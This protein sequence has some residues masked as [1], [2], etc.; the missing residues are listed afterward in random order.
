MAVTKTLRMTLLRVCV[1]LCV[2]FALPAFAST[3]PQKTWAFVVGLVDFQDKSTWYTFPVRNRREPEVV[4]ALRK[5]GVPADHIVLLIDKQATL[6]TMQRELRQLLKRTQPGDF[7]FVYYTGHGW[8]EDGKFYWVPYDGTENPSLWEFGQWTGEVRKYFRGDR[9]LVA[10][11][12]CYSGMLRR[13]AARWTGRPALGVLSSGPEDEDS[14]IFWTFT[15][16]VVD[17]LSGNPVADFNKDG[18]VS[19]AEMSRLVTREMAFVEE[20]VA[21]GTSSASFAAQQPIFKVSRALKMDEGKLAEVQ[22]PDRKRRGRV[23]Q[24]EG[25]RYL[26]RWMGTFQAIREEWVD[27]QAIQLLR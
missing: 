1:L 15:D 8:S 7:L 25:L 11:D 26:V 9:F 2:S 12:C 27:S 10:S 5:Q 18:Q 22:R 20:Q 3:P 24:H 4:A 6:A 14:T 21:G 19:F 13:Y 16:I 23:L 17:L